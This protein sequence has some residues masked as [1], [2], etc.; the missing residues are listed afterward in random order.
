MHTDRIVGLPEADS[1][2]LL[3]ELFDHL[4]APENTFV[5]DWSVG[6][7][8]VWDNIALQHHRPDFPATAPRTMQRVCINEKTTAELVPNIAELMR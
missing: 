3:G 8:A 4:Y 1:E 2:A 6:D 5:L 7:L